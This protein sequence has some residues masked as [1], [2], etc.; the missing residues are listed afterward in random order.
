MTPNKN[1]LITGLIILVFCFFALCSQA[2]IVSLQF[3]PTG[4]GPNTRIL[5]N[6]FAGVVPA[7]NW[8]LAPNTGTAG[9]GSLTNLIDSTGAATT[10]DLAYTSSQVN[11]PRSSSGIGTP[12]QK[13]FSGILRS[14]RGQ[15]PVVPVTLD[16]S[17][18][19]IFPAYDLIL[20]L[21]STNIAGTISLNGG[22]PI[23][24]SPTSPN[25]DNPYVFTEITPSSP[26]GNYIVF[27]NLTDDSPSIELS[28]NGPFS[29]I[30]VS[31]LQ[32]VAVPEPQ[33]ATLL[34][35]G[36]LLGFQ[37]R[38]RFSKRTVANA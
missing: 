4:F 27:R 25:S 12:N 21:S 8:N 32:I 6:E 31:G 16:F 1:S 3:P 37:S 13:L 2:Q 24:I 17:E 14:G 22:T 34:L 30:G 36:C 5:P 18:V 7:A 26:V 15:P 33:T 10:I 20:Y 35:I 11:I 23:N 29:N 38:R 19:N 28:A 9:S